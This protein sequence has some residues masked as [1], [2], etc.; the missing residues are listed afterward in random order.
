MGYWTINISV[1]LLFLR[2]QNENLNELYILGHFDIKIQRLKLFYFIFMRKN[3]STVKGNFLCFS[4]KILVWKKQKQFLL[5]NVA[6]RMNMMV[7]QMFPVLLHSIY[8]MLICR[9]D[10]MSRRSYRRSLKSDFP[11][12]IV[13]DTFVKRMSK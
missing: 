10:F 5:L 4:L 13:H 3:L 2:E 6:S 8:K 9:R 7:S 11:L 12:K 1:K